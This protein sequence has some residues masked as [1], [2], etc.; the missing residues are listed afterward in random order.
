MAQDEDSLHQQA[1]M[2]KLYASEW[3]STAGHPDAAGTATS[4]TTR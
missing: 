4:A 2:G 3:A 1:A